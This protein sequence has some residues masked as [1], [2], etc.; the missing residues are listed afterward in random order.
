M[1]PSLNF[2]RDMF[3]LTSIEEIRREPPEE[4]QCEIYVLL[5]ADRGLAASRQLHVELDDPVSGAM[6]AIA[7]QDREMLRLL[8]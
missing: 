7:P 5:G 8:R 4:T 1:E 6:L 3:K 2:Y